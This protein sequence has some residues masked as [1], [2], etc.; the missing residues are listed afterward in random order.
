MLTCWFRLGGEIFDLRLGGTLQLAGL[1]TL[2]AP[3]AIIFER[4]Q[5]I[6]WNWL[7]CDLNQQISNNSNPSSPNILGLCVPVV[8]YLFI[9][10]TQRHTS[11]R[12]EAKAMF[13]IIVCRCATPLHAVSTS[14]SS[15]VRVVSSIIEVGELAQSTIWITASCHH[16][17][18][19]KKKHKNIFNYCFN[20]I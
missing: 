8:P 20:G 18:C 13:C 10:Q 2:V 3:M 11:H 7:Q 9:T 1:I 16:H 6:P 14:V 4:Q 17:Y 15:T 19:L 5:L 12:T